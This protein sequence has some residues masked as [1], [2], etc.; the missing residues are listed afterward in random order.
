MNAGIV[1]N[2]GFEIELLTV[3]VLTG[4]W[5]WDLNFN[6]TKNKSTLVSL[7]PG[8]S[9]TKLLWSSVAAQSYTEVESINLT[10]QEHQQIVVELEDIFMEIDEIGEKEFVSCLNCAVNTFILLFS[11]VYL[12]SFLSTQTGL[13]HAMFPST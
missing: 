13:D 6:F 10:E 8:I 12:F 1:E 3:P 2:K 9:T 11:F 7:A 4:N 5:R